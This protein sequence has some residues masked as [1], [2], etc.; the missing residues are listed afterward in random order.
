MTSPLDYFSPERLGISLSGFNFNAM[1]MYTLYGIIAIAIGGLIL[2][3]QYNKKLY[4]YKVRVYRVRENG[5]VKEINGKGGF[6]NRQTGAPFFRINFGFRNNFDLTETPKLQFMDEED[7][8]YYKQIDINTFI[9]LER[10]FDDG[11]LTFTP[12]ES[13]VKYGAILSV[14]KIREVLNTESTL[15]KLAPYIALII[16]AVV[17]IVAYWFLM[18]KCKG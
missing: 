14:Q 7:R 4:K 17:F 11:D 5:K 8:V 18:D 13:D 10:K 2:Y 15:K 6:I 3:F 9:Q 1:L 16:L 12:V